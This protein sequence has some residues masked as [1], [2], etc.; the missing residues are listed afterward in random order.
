LVYKYNFI[1]CDGYQD[2]CFEIRKIFKQYLEVHN[3]NYYFAVNEAVC[4]AA[5]YAKAGNAMAPIRIKIEL[6]ATGI[7]TTV[8]SETFPAEM[9]D[10]RE[11]LRGFSI[12]TE[13]KGKTWQEV[14]KDQL[15][16]R[17]FWLMLSACDYI[18]VEKHGQRV[19]LHTPKAD[20]KG[21]VQYQMDEIISRFFIDDQGMIL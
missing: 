6:E 1:G 7:K 13:Y 16:G 15:S 4:N 9:L 18:V 19:I 5:R 8:E 3:L 10:Y 21:L 14:W 17:G 20:Q 2:C 12:N 11:K